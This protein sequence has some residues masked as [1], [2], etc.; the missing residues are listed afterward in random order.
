MSGTVDDK[1]LDDDDDDDDVI[2]VMS[3]ELMVSI[4]KENQFF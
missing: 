4:R 3:G 1:R 2:I